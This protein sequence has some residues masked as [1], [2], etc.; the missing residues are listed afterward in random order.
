M[1]RGLTDAQQKKALLL[2]LAGPAV[3]DIFEI[4]PEAEGDD[5]YA[6]TVGALNAYFQPHVNIPYE[7]HMF[8]Q[9]SQSDTE[10][11]DQFA[12][13]LM[14][15][16]NRCEFGGHKDEQIRDQIIDRCHSA[17]LR[18]ALLEKKD[19]TLDK[20]L[21]IG[22][23]KE[24]AERQAQ[25]IGKPTAS[26]KPVNNNFDVNAVRGKFE[27]RCYRCG[28]QGHQGKDKNCPAHDQTC[29]KCSKVGHFASQCR[30]KVG[31]ARPKQQL[32][33]KQQSSSRQSYQRGKQKVNAVENHDAEN[34]FAFMIGDVDE[35]EGTV[36]VKVG[37]VELHGLLIDSGATC[38]LI[39]K[40]TWN[41]LKQKRIKCRSEKT[42]KK[43]YSY[44]S[45]SALQTVGKFTTEVEIPSQKVEA[46]FVVID[47]KG[48][49]ILGKK[50]AT[51]LGILRVGIPE[52]VNQLSVDELVNK[53]PH[54]FQGVGRLKD[55]EVKLH[56]NP[57]VQ[58]VAQKA[59]KIPYGLRDKVETEINS[60]LAQGIIEPVQGPT[61]WV[62]PVVVVP[63]GSGVRLCVDMRQANEAIIRER[64]P[65]PTV[66]E[67]LE[68]LNQ[69]TVF[70][71]LDLR[72]GFHQLQL[73]EESRPITTFITHVGLFR[74]ARLLFGV[75]SA[76]E[77]YQ[78]IIK[79][80]L[81]D[82]PGTANIADDIVVHGKDTV[83]HDER[84][85]RVFQRLTEVG[86]TLNKEKCQLQMNRLEF[87]GHLLTDRGVGPTEARVEAVLKARE[88]TSVSEVRSFLGLV[89]FSAKFIPNMA[90]VAEPLRKLC[91]QNVRFEWEQEQREAF[92]E[93]K[94]RL[95]N[96]ETLAYFDKT[97]PTE[98][99]ADAGP[100]GLGAVLVQ[101]QNDERRVV[102]YASRSLSEV[103][104]RYSQTEKE[105]LALVWACERFHVFLGGIE[106]SLVTD[107]KPLEVIYGKRSKPS[108]RIERW[109]LRLQQYNFKV[110]YR[111]GRD[112]I[113]DALSRLT[114]QQ[115]I[116]SKNIAEDYVRFVSEQA[117]PL[118]V[119][120][121]EIEKESDKDPDL[122]EIRQ[123][124][125]SGDWSKCSASVRAVRDEI[126][127]V[128]RVVLRGTRIVMPKAL[129]QK[130]IML[131]HEGH[132]GIVKTKARLRT[133]V[134]FPSMDRMTEEFCRTCHE[135]QLVSHLSKPEPMK[136]TELPQGPWQHLAADLL[137][138][139]PNGDYLFVV[140][141]YYSRFFEVRIVKS[142]TSS[143]MIYCL[144]DIFAV[145]GLPIS[146]KTD[147]A[148]NFTS[149][150]FEQYLR[151]CAVD[152]H[153][154]I[155]LWP[156]SNGEVERQNRTL[157][158]YMK[159][160]HS[161][162]KNLKKELH[163]FLLAYRTTPHST[164]GI[165]PAEMLFRRKIRTK[166]PEIRPVD[167]SDT[168]TD[169]DL[170]TVRYRDT[171]EKR[172]GKNY[173][174]AKRGATI[175]DIKTGDKVLLQQQQNN[176][177]SLPYYPELFTVA[178][179]RGHEV[180]VTSDEDGRSI[181]RNVAFVKKYVSGSHDP[182]LQNPDGAVSNTK[183]EQNQ[184][185]SPAPMPVQ[186]DANPVPMTIQNTADA[187]QPSNHDPATTQDQ[188]QSYQ[189][190]IRRSCRARHT[191]S[192]L[193]DFVTAVYIP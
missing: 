118:A 79:Q 146:L 82:C 46:E 92:S 23:A 67:V 36:S 108:A 150:E 117:A 121:Q 156:Q 24:A 38:N 120:I 16:A 148:P 96:A 44:A 76:P 190:T 64:H 163:K 129:Q 25:A 71:K 66:D 97:A 90:T 32:P 52:K 173:T 189:S 162:G 6:K 15:Q 140:V 175:S 147:N 14:Q 136:R 166:L 101:W 102:Y 164:T 124:V 78:H 179:R 84:L 149:G 99:I 33:S 22:R 43:I 9:I 98:V 27:G 181:R 144:E 105:A 112:N 57:E 45:K 59:R 152:H 13:R 5:V 29:R 155:P 7:R 49:S 169:L 139:L 20:V 77:L 48:Q 177:L 56:I 3:Q 122:E 62:S 35:I 187:V 178:D 192:H 180:T 93:L 39:D 85:A 138:P 88:P 34:E 154:S 83:E 11:I 113:A 110:V 174:D 161:Q 10:S 123:A 55:Y 167:I 143:S 68:E 58:P 28:R 17:V 137:G 26:Y 130:T 31:A 159:I 134:W 172:K 145:H 126:T 184:D 30:T 73:H 131:A 41:E 111:R 72:L 115:N 8:R 21:E 176:K 119:R 12:T 51:E 75:N 186:K 165:A 182:S 191:P 40:V 94:S 2:H 135:C 127:V 1:A 91:R 185:V 151:D 106:F 19:I 80:V 63:K 89:N 171:E 47:G 170:E 142:V 160:V 183:L 103:E 70:S 61:P 69:S 81:Q 100:I 18:K 4:L 125:K 158:K 42:T 193:K 116:V 132:Q 37:G 114:P 54:L 50:T 53:Y 128:G 107:H 168:V 87:M 65:I 157:L 133:K 188:Q 109:V 104:R 153:T 60:L 74:Y 95:A 86:L 141:D